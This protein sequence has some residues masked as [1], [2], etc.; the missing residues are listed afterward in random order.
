MATRNSAS[1]KKTERYYKSRKDKV[2]DGVCSGLAEYLAVDVTLVR[3]LCLLSIFVN[4]IGFLAYLIAMIIVPA[5]PDHSKDKRIRK[6]TS[7]YWGIILIVLGLYFIA[8]KVFPHFYWDFPFHLR[9]FPW[10]DWPWHL[11]WP[12]GL[13]VLGIFYILFAMQKKE[14]TK[15]SNSQQ[16]QP[17]SGKSV[18]KLYKNRK[19]KML[20]GVCAGMGDYFGIDT[21]LIRILYV[22]FT[23]MTSIVIGVV[24]YITLV[25]VLPE[26][27]NIEDSN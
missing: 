11:V 16:S 26:K 3:I 12:L 5:N 23:L 27:N 22:V 10:W 21:T 15:N 6:D 8:D 24:V 7:V 4:G 1:K 20:A 17:E 18:K 13:V 25:F 9:W 2:I 14:N 19:K